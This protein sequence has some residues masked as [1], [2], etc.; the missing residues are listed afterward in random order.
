MTETT[1]ELVA[2]P[3]ASDRPGE[4]IR[5]AMSAAREEQRVKLVEIVDPLDGTRAPAFITETGVKSLD[6]EAFDQ[7]RASPTRR[8]G[9]ATFT[10]VDSFIEHVN[11]FK[12][13]DSAIFANED[14]KAPRLTAVLD[15][16]VAGGFDKDPRHGTHRSAYAFPL[17]PE[18]TAWFGKN[19]EAM[20]MVSFAAFLEDHIVDVLQEP[21][22]L[23]EAADAFVKATGGKFATP[24]KLIEIARGLQVNEKSVVKEARNLSSGEAEIVFDVEHTGADGKPLKLPN[25]FVIAIPVFKRSPVVYRLIARLRYRK[26][27]EGLVF[28]FELWRP[29]LVFTDAFEEAVEEV[30]TKTELP[31]FLGSPEA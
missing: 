4:L 16:H 21:G 12:D 7:Y 24:S 15:Y 9:T 29:D 26:T 2:A 20:S 27:G 28:W 18:W 6:A 10:R 3:I 14:P 31:V 5:E 17:S 30:R 22:T 25:L 23:G 1:A 19:A 11:R 8:K 13:E